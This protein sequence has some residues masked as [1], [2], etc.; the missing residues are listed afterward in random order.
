ME[1]NHI[2]RALILCRII[3]P[4]IVKKSENF[5][6]YYILK[7]GLPEM[8]KRKKERK[9]QLRSNCTKQ[10]TF[11]DKEECTHKN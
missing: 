10:L 3:E 2:I 1:S 11:S 8:I 6:L 5:Q 7:Y 9:T 4:K